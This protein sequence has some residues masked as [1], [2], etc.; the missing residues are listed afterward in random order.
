MTLDNNDVCV[1]RVEVAIMEPQ[2]D[3]AEVAADQNSNQ[4]DYCF[5]TSAVAFVP[6]WNW[7]CL[8]RQARGEVKRA[9]E[10][11]SVT[12]PGPL[13]VL[14]AFSDSPSACQQ[15]VRG[16]TPRHL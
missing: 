2:K 15:K 10:A 8:C 14:L 1:Q 5:G 9:A 13:V 7:G 6:V 12:D 3:G 4:R 16:L 11:I